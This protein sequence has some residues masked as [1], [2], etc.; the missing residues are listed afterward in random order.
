MSK[1]DLNGLADQWITNSVKLTRWLR[2]ADNAPTLSGPQASALAIIVYSGGIMP[3]TLADL[4][5]VKR[6]TI[7]RI[8]TQLHEMGLIQR[9]IS[10]LEKR[11]TTVTSTALGQL[12]I[13]EGQNRRAEPL[14]A[15]FHNLSDT[16]LR[17]LENA[18]AIIEGILQDV[19]KRAV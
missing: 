5:E 4:E 14:V 19:S 6:P 11:S 8:L 3:S 15:A 10:A 7:A 18:G 2:A 13:V 17:V 9:T 12:R 16:Q 1:S